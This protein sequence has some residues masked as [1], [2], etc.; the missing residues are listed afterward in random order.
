MAYVKAKDVLSPKGSWQLIRVLRDPGPSKDSD[1]KV[2][3]ALG[4]WGGRPV[5]VSRWNGTDRSPIGMPQSR[6]L[7][8]WYVHDDDSYPSLVPYLEKIAPDHAQFL[9]G[10]LALKQAV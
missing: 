4:F 2:S 8:I 1:Y 6:G 5:I 7:P 9:Q 3:W 10:F